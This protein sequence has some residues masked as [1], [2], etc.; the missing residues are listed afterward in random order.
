MCVFV[1]LQILF[2][3]LF[4]N[5]LLFAEEVS[6]F[7]YVWVTFIG[8]SLATKLRNH[9]KVDFFVLKLPHKARLF[10]NLLVDI[11]SELFADIFMYMGNPLYGFQ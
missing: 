8:L 3:Y 5:P 11:G 4:K 9:V 1:F 10:L 2:R 6:R 7:S